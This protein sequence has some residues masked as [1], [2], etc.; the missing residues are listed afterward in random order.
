[1][2]KNCLVIGA[3]FGGIASA[4]RLRRL[5]YNVTIVDKNPHLGVEHKFINAGNLNLM[6]A[7]PS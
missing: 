7:Q 5:G 2:S 6:P 4:L 3:G 1:M